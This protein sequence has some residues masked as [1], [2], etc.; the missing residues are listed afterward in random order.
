MCIKTNVKNYVMESTSTMIENND[1]IRRVTLSIT[2]LHCISQK[3]LW[4]EMFVNVLQ[5]VLR[6]HVKKQT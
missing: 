5:F 3:S 6:F 4:H 2:K 1:Q